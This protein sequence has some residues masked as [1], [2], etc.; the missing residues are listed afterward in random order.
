M[1]ELKNKNTLEEIRKF[2]SSGN[3]K[4]NEIEKLVMKNRFWPDGISHSKIKDRC[5]EILYYYY[6][7]IDLNIE[8]TKLLLNGN[9]NKECSHCNGTGKISLV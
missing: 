8:D 6:W 1:I 5:A 4:S 2:L 9:I 3:E 7:N